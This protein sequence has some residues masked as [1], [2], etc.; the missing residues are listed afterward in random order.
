MLQDSRKYVHL[1]FF[2]FE[3][4]DNFSGLP[5]GGYGIRVDYIIGG[6]EISFC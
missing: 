3:Y 1:N 6:C 5:C 4:R 2:E